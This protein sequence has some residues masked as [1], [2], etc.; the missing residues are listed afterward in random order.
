MLLR[1]LMLILIYFW[2]LT[3][4]AV[5]SPLESTTPEPLLPSIDRP[6][7]S[8]EIYRIE[9]TIAEL[10]AQAQDKLEMGLV[11]EAFSLWY[12]ELR[13]QRSL[14]LLEELSALGK[15]GAI[16]W[17]ENRPEDARIIG[18]RLETI[19]QDLDQDPALLLALAQ[20]YQQLRRW[21]EATNIYQALLAVADSPQAKKPILDNLG[22]L[23]LARFDY[24][25]AGEVYTELLAIANL[26]SDTFQESIYLRKLAEIYSETAKPE[27]AVVI[28]EQLVATYTDNQQL[29]EL[30]QLKLSLGL[31]YEALNQIE[32]AS[33]NF[34]EAYTLAWSQEQYG[35]AAQAKLNQANLY[36]NSGALDQALKIYQELIDIYQ[37]SYN[38]YGLMNT[39]DQIGKIYTAQNKYNEALSAF[40][41]GLAVA[42]SLNS[43]QDYFNSQIAQIRAKLNE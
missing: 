30:A 7:T 17:Q 43:E 41:Q 2:G 31:D 16:A 25:N 23:Y 24:V 34:Q 39:Y 14:G 12:R 33:Q 13:L 37:T 21:E 8:F 11:D 18:D 4:P 27:N 29:A 15:V 32:A 28:K 19:E 6:L 35:L 26:Q 1:F 3:T 5:A 22:E 38:L 40:E 9:K 36:Y 42:K 10:D 20:A